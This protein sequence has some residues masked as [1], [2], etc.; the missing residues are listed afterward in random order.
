MLVGRIRGTKSLI[1][2]SCLFRY[3]GAAILD[4]YVDFVDIEDLT[5]FLLPK[6]PQT[7]NFP[8]IGEFI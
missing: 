2:S 8:I 1:H 6:V 7:P 3:M 4:F 5:S